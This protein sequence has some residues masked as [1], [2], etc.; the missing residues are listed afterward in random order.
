MIT[1]RLRAFCLLLLLPG[2]IAQAAV[3]ATVSR[4]E[5]YLGESLDLVIKS[6]EAASASPDFTPLAAGL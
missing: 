1:F 4:A 5:L 6:D 2:G 3:Q